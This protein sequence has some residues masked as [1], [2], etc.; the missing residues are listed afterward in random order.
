MQAGKAAK[1]W[2]VLQAL[3]AELD[4]DAPLM[5]A[6]A[7]ARIAMEGDGGLDQ[8]RLADELKAS[9]AAASRTAQALSKVH[10]LKDRSGYGL[11]DIEMGNLDRR[12]RV[13]KLND[14]GRRA[15]ARVM[16]E[17]K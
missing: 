5:Q 16:D 4:R 10:Y 8:S 6:L 1:A 12:S 17:L 3:A 7:F 2:R 13:L 15:F 14:K 9:G 11:I